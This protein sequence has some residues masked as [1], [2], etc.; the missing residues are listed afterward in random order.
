[1]GARV[2]SRSF[3]ARPADVLARRLLGCRL[4]RLLDDGTRLSGIIVETEAYLG[5][6]DQAA[7]CAGGRRTPRTE[8]MYMAPGTS[9]V[10]FTY[11][12]HY[13]MNVS[14]AAVGLPHAVLI[15]ALEP[16]EGIERMMSHRAASGRTMRVEDLCNGPAKLCQA[17]AINRSLN[18]VDLVA[19]DRLWIERARRIS[20]AHVQTT[21]RI[22]IGYAG[23]WV[24][25]PL[26]WLVS[27][28]ACVSRRPR[29]R[30]LST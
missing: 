8:P 6:E 26:R 13:C 17:F 4:V 24:D 23:A 27:S 18:A 3:Y 29:A 10:Y 2:L 15:R 11:G 21:P 14:A 1:M 9:Y 22:G 28:S 16:G 20:D 25:K 12:M 19:G 7:H 30:K 5:E